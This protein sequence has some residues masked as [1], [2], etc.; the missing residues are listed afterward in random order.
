LAY[1]QLNENNLPKLWQQSKDYTDKLTEPFPEFERLGQNKPSDDIDPDYPNVTDGTAASIKQKT[2]KRIVQQVPGGTIESTHAPEW[3][4]ATSEDLLENEILPYANG[5]YPLLQKCRLALE[6]AITLGSSLAHIYF[7][8]R[9]GR[10]GVD[11]DLIHWG[12]YGIHPGT[13]AA[14]NDHEIFIRSWYT[15]SDIDRLISDEQQRTKQSKARVKAY[16]QEAAAAEKFNAENHEAIA[17]RQ[18]MPAQALDKPDEYEPTW[19]VQ[20]LEEV[21]QQTTN[22]DET[23]KTSSEK[24]RGTDADFIELVTGFQDGLGATFYTFH[25]DTKKIVRRKTNPDKRGVMP[26]TWLFGDVSNASPLGRGIMELIGGLQNL[27]DSDMQAYQYERWLNMQPTLLNYGGVEDVYIA[28][29]NVINI[30]DP[31]A[32]IEPLRTSTTAIEHYPELYGLQKSQILN[33]VRSPDISISADVGNPGFSKTPAGIKSQNAII[34]TDDNAWRKQFESWFEE[35]CETMLN[36]YFAQMQGVHTYQLQDKTVDHLNALAKKGKFDSSM[37][38]D[39]EI[40]IDFD[41][42]YGPLKFRV[43][44]QSSRKADEQEQMQGLELTQKFIDSSSAIQNLIGPVT[45][46]GLYNQFVS[47][48]GLDN[49]DDIKID[50]E[51][52]KATQQK[53]QSQA[54][55]PSAKDIID[56]LNM[57]FDELP[58]D[59]Q[60]MLIQRTI[61]YTP[62]QPTPSAIESMTKVQEAKNKTLQAQS[63]AIHDIDQAADNNAQANSES[64][65]PDE[66]RQVEA[67]MTGQLYDDF[68]QM[69]YSD[70]QIAQAIQIHNQQRQPLQTPQQPPSRQPQQRQTNRQEPQHGQR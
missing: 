56:A 53:Q 44:A 14:T 25:P 26:R 31:N 18:I 10:F 15:E 9:M 34:S 6:D 4:C 17:A 32:K 60:S 65:S 57:K 37:L 7:Y 63:S 61:G 40:T 23:G 35:T 62:Q 29:R 51:Q 3:F 13:K 27:I 41:Q 67:E 16:E 28:P 64:P 43:E 2:P 66:L 49:S 59:V 22:K 24:D 12:D 55:D 70:N 48:S 42:D 58:A 50:I 69:G 11:F 30:D 1:S 33:L 20:A 38:K 19:D 54:L 47:V 39:N 45:Q 46:A 8:E 52:L 68:R 5:G 21:K 36:L